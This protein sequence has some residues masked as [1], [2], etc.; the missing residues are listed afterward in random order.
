MNPHT[1][2]PLTVLEGVEFEKSFMT[3]LT[4]IGE[5]ALLEGYIWYIQGPKE[6][7]IVDT[8]VKPESFT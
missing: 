8:G 3:Y 2:R 6:N 5:K 1:I 7:I 4:N